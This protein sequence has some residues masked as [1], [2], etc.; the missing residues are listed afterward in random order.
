M[1][2]RTLWARI[3]RKSFGGEQAQDSNR[4]IEGRIEFYEE[5]GRFK[6]LV[7]TMHWENC[8]TFP[9]HKAECYTSVVCRA[10]NKECDKKETCWV[11]QRYVCFKKSLASV[12]TAF[13][14]MENV[15]MPC[16]NSLQTVT[17]CNWAHQTGHNYL[18]GNLTARHW[19]RQTQGNPWRE[20]RNNLETQTNCFNSELC[21]KTFS[22]NSD[23]FP[24]RVCV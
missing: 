14:L 3:E 24:H 10:A 2:W 4:W 5:L 6:E 1:N 16:R 15:I 22:Q 18:E 9:F 21:K 19:Q 13:I 7:S 20:E 11:Y 17:W 12:Y 8:S 23:I